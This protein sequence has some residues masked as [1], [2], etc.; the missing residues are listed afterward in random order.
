MCKEIETNLDFITLDFED[1]SEECLVL[2]IYEIEGKK[3]MS[4][5]AGV[6]DGEDLESDDVEGY[7]Y[8]YVDVDDEEFE[9]LDIESDEEF[10]R[11]AAK[12]EAFEAARTE[13]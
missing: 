4:L 13:E 8:E 11:I 5:V 12:I 10:E 1:G 2:G 3:Y 7:I 6:E 9:L